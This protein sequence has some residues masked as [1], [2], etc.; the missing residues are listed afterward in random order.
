MMKGDEAAPS[1]SEDE[2]SEDK[3]E[4]PAGIIDSML[5]PPDFVSDS[6]T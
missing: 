4:K 1:T 2:W 5:T 6:E 3:A